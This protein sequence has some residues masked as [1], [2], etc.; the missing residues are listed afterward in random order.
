M[1]NL[2]VIIVVLT[3]IVA[4]GYAAMILFSGSE[5]SELPLEPIE[6][7]STP[8]ADEP[9]SLPEEPARPP[10]GQGPDKKDVVIEDIRPHSEWTWRSVGVTVTVVDVKSRNPVPREKITFTVFQNDLPVPSSPAS[11]KKTG[12]VFFDGLMP[13]RYRFDAVADKERF[14][15]LTLCVDPGMR[16]DRK[17]YVSKPTPL[18]IKVVR[19]RSGNPIVGAAIGASDLISRGMTDSK[20]LFR[21]KR[22]LIPDPD[23]AVVVSKQGYFTTLVHPFC[24]KLM[25]S[26]KTALVTVILKPLGGSSRL[27]GIVITQ[28]GNPLKR[29]TLRLTPY[30]TKGT[31]A[32]MVRFI[33]TVTNHRGAFAFQE[34]AADTYLLEG[35][36]QSWTTRNSASFP[37]LVSR[38]ITIGQG[39]TL[40]NQEIVCNL[41]PL[42]VTGVVLR[43]D[44][45]EPVADV[46]VS[47]NG[48][49]EG[50]AGGGPG[51]PFHFETV[52]TNANG[53][54][55]IARPFQP[56]EINNLL[57][58]TGLRLTPPGGEFEI[59][60]LQHISKS[61]NMMIGD[62][63]RKVPIRIWLRGE[64][65]IELRGM[66]TDVAGNPLKG[67]IAEATPLADIDR[68]RYRAVTNKNGEFIITR[69]FGGTWNIKINLPNGPAL[70][71]TTTLSTD[72]LPKKELF[73]APGTS[74]IE[75]VVD[76]K[77]ASYF[78]RVT[79]SGAGFVIEN[80]RLPT[81]GHFLFEHLPAG[82]VT[83]TVESY[84]TQRF[85]ERSLVIRRASVVLVAGMTE[86][87][88][89]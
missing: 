14:G 24:E 25:N 62:L 28:D 80:K 85:E 12:R 57:Q 53:I 40:E 33:E 42:P 89:L 49:H 77:K 87:I 21:S 60:R 17:L 65:S 2:L 4:I 23:L 31:G 84:S 48:H 39:E 36:L 43:A 69:L 71:R 88:N 32:G 27:S 54:F 45:L 10:A 34:L 58:R 3:A 46:A 86:T 79:I 61:M 30:S 64:N 76:L 15:S 26:R 20:G 55:S 63:M 37:P 50:K 41:S 56:T 81:G 52:R 1:K 29:W 7:D 9:V 73:V 74:R 59:F 6:E 70:E 67:V 22:P 16:Y 18:Q 38:N 11:G 8:V 13:G 47:C 5:L 44:T 75:G 83:I 78:P 82:E 66:V 68:K 35:L 19:A 72:A 51:D